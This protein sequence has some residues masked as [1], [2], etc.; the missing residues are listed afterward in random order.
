MSLDYGGPRRRRPLWATALIGGAV[1]TLA[2]VGGGLGYDWYLH[3]TQAVAESRSLTA[4][5]DIK[6]AP[7]PTLTPA[8]YA[9]Q[10]AKPRMI[11]EFQKVQFARR[12]GHADCA[13]VAYRDAAGTGGHPVCQFTAPA[14]LVITVGGLESYFAPDI[15]VPATVSVKHGRPRCVLATRLDREFTLPN[16]GKP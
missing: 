2:V 10:G 6:G 16:A 9:A 14:L 15:G 13:V 12:F 8:A 11:F 7:C 5:F 4:A 1:L 3:Q